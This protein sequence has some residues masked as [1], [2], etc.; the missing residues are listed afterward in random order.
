MWI[1]SFREIS[2]TNPSISGSK[3]QTMCWFKKKKPQRFKEIKTLNWQFLPSIFSPHLD[4]LY[5]DTSVCVWLKNTC[6]CVCMCLN[7][8]GSRWERRG[9]GVKLQRLSLV[10]GGKAGMKRHVSAISPVWVSSASFFFCCMSIVFAL[11]L[12]C[13]G[14]L[15]SLL[16]KS[17]MSSLM[18]RLHCP[19]TVLV[20]V[21]SRD[22]FQLSL[23]KVHVRDQNLP[24]HA[25]LCKI[26]R[27]FSDSTYKTC[28][29]WMGVE[30]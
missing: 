7:M 16:W 1:C 9:L 8:N 3:G 17:L 6:V 5:C 18:L 19:H 15:S 27:P 30:S 12:L 23:C 4:I 14:I 13:I 28:G 29:C 2:K 24:D 11:R 20:N 22:H 26:L 25:K 10:F 21:H